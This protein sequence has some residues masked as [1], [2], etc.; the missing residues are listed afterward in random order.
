MLDVARELEGERA[1]RA[2]NAVVAIELAALGEDD[3]HGGEAHHVVDDRRLAEEALRWP[4]SAACSGRCRAC[5]R[6]FR[7]SS[8]FAA[9]IGAGAH[10]HEE[11]EGI[12]R[13]LDV[14]AEPV[15]LA[16]R[17]RWLRAARSRRADIPTECR[18]SPCGAAGDGRDRHAFDEAEWIAFHQ[19]AVGEGAAV[20]FVGVAG[21]VFLV[22]L[23]VVNRLPLDAG[24]EAGA[25]AAA[26]ARCRNLGDDVDAASSSGL[27]KPFKAA[28]LAIIVDR[29][30]IGDAAARE[31]QPLLILEIGDLFG[32]AVAELV[33]LASRSPP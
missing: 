17:S 8:F 16:S 26:Q 27:S 25:A 23:E 3:R 9:D 20:A 15:G 22:G 14:V 1:A 2:A 24:R 7:A 31:R 32:Q 33:R 4:G 6:C 30:R 29:Q 10:A 28:V 18:C 5:P 21:D 11:V 13:S 19:H 12:I